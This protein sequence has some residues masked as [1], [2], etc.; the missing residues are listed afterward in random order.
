MKIDATLT[1][2]ETCYYQQEFRKDLIVLHYTAGGSAPSS[3]AWWRKQQNRIG[4][5]YVIDRDGT[6][7]E[8][9]PP[10]FWAHHIGARGLRQQCDRSIGIELANWGWLARSGNDLKTYT[11]R[12]LCGIEERH[13]YVE[14]LH[15]GQAFW[16]RMPDEQ[17]RAA[18][19]LV[20]HLCERFTISI[21]IHPDVRVG[22]ANPGFFARHK[23][24]AVHGNFRPDKPEI[25]PAGAGIFA[26][27]VRA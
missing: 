4:T 8:A 21:D 19:E 10:E 1:L 24:I 9:F 17:L 3:I 16:E 27:L 5:A 2:P 22:V 7:Y 26:L 11:G 23:G 14:A 15:R 18:A 25:G 6:I 13:A 20:S 12:V